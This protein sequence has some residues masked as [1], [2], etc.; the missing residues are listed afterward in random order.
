M[1]SIKYRGMYLSLLTIILLNVVKPFIDY[2]FGI[3]YQFLTLIQIAVF[4]STVLILKKITIDY[5]FIICC[6]F[7]FIRST[8]ELIFSEDAYLQVITSSSKWILIY[9]GISILNNSKISKKEID[10]IRDIC[11]DL[12]FCLLCILIGEPLQ[13]RSLLCN[14]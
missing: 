2:Y 14:E 9:I 7:I 8:I 6:T 1:E 10:S 4:L 5:Y 3:N 13:A 12:D 11:Q